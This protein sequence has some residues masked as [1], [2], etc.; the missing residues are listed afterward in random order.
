MKIVSYINSGKPVYSIYEG[1]TSIFIALLYESYIGKEIKAED[2]NN[3]KIVVTEKGLKF[4]DHIV[5]SEIIEDDILGGFEATVKGYDEAVFFDPF[6]CYIYDGNYN[7]TSSRDYKIYRCKDCGKIVG[8]D[9]YVEGYCL[10]CFI[11]TG[12]QEIFKDIQFS[13]NEEYTE[14]EKV[15][16]IYE[17]VD[18][19]K[20]KVKRFFKYEEVAKKAQ[21]I[22]CA[23]VKDIPDKYVEKIV[24]GFAA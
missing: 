7:E 5:N 1:D 17:I 10:D 22:V 24:G 15:S 2:F 9:K 19:F 23:Y 16:E 13:T 8:Y 21:E 6:T 4:S 11:E 3:K 14:Y 18:T 12:I 20:G